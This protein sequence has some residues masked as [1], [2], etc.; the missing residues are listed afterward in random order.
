MEAWPACFRFAPV[1]FDGSWRLDRGGRSQ[2]QRRAELHVLGAE[3]ESHID[4]RGAA[5]VGLFRAELDEL[6]LMMT[7]RPSASVVTGPNRSDHL[8]LA[9]SSSRGMMRL[10]RTP[11]RDLVPAFHRPFSVNCKSNV[12]W[13]REKLSSEISVKT[14]SPDGV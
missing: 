14:F 13:M 2:H 7:K 11:E 5:G 10:V 6:R 1:A 3:I 12:R 8:A 9:A 4:A